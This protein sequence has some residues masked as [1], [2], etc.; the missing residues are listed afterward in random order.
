MESK[1]GQGLPIGVVVTLIIAVVVLVAIVL[2]FTGR[3][4]AGTQQFS[5]LSPQELETAVASCQFS[6]DTANSATRTDADCPAWQ[7]R[8]CTRTVTVAGNAYY[9]QSSLNTQENVDALNG[10]DG[11]TLIPG[12]TFECVSPA[13]CECE[14]TT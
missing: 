5:E 1:K 8:Y 4:R 11:V 7:S 14:L 13:G 3:F 6:C 9:C 12:Y 10:R 2:F